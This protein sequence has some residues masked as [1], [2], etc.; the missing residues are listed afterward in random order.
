MKKFRSN[1]ALAFA[2]LFISAFS[3][4]ACGGKKEANNEEAETEQTDEVKEAAESTEHPADNGGS[5]H[6]ADTT[7]H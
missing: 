5:E 6:P 3:F 1:L 2:I 4:T 7:D